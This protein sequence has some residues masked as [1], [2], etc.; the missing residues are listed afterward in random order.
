MRINTKGT[1]IS[2]T[3]AIVDYLNKKLATVEKYIN[4]H[5]DVAMLDVE[6]GRTT[7]HHKSG[8]IFRA[9]INLKL[10]GDSLRAVREAEDLY[11]AIDQ[12][13]DEIVDLLTTHADKRRTL[14]RRG[15]AKIKNI[16]KGLYRRNK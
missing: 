15:A 11:A 16:L 9:E 2:L 14:L 4:S 10:K 6:V 5:Q 7:Q 12:V 13:K 3:P 8:D 1:N